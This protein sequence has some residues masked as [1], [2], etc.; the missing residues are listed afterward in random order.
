MSAA[1]GSLFAHHY[2]PSPVCTIDFWL[3]HFKISFHAHRTSTCP[4]RISA[5]Y[6][7]QSNVGEPRRFVQGSEGAPLEGNHPPPAPSAACCGMLLMCLQTR[8]HPA[9]R[10][11]IT[12]RVSTNERKQQLIPWPELWAIRQRGGHFNPYSLS[13]GIGSC[14]S[15]EKRREARQCTFICTTPSLTFSCHSRWKSIPALPSMEPS[16]NNSHEHLISLLKRLL[17]MT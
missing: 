4:L 10:Q 16:C 2:P 13:G 9:I 3:L 11:C 12:P 15:N 6:S 17:S 8:C 1:P 5:P 7:H 14:F